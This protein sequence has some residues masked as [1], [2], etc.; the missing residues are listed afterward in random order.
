MQ[1]HHATRFSITRA[2]LPLAGLL[3]AALAGCGN[4]T[5]SS[6]N[7]PAAMGSTHQPV[8]TSQAD[9]KPVTEVCPSK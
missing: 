9:W 4:S 5:P 7:Q 1:H 8:A 3:L 6:T 2:A